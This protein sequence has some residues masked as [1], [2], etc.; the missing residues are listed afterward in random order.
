MGRYA[1]CARSV[2]DKKVAGE[3]APN[4]VDADS[5]DE[6]TGLCP[7]CA[8]EPEEPEQQQEEDEDITDPQLQHFTSENIDHEHPQPGSEPQPDPELEPQP[9]AIP[10][11]LPFEPAAA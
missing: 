7:E 2:F 10:I 8:P 5:F 1:P 9:T 6:E 4:V 11:A 3:P